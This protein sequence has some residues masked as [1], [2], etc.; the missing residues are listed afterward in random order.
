M[1]TEFIL[2]GVIAILL[3]FTVAVG[4][5]TYQLPKDGWVCTNQDDAENCTQYTQK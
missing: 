3:I 1:K 4:N 5:S 2:Y